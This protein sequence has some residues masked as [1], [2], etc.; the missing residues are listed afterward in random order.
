FWRVGVQ[1]QVVQAPQERLNGDLSL[2]P[3][4]RGAEAEVQPMSEGNM[5]VVHSRDVESVRI[6]KLI[7]I[8]VCRSECDTD[9]L[10]LAHG[11]SAEIKIYLC[12]P[13][14]NLNGTFETEELFDRRP[15]Q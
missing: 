11:F 10:A 8:T 4:Q 7:W 9:F 12:H 13:R 5:T 14:R 3:R 1:A 2:K 15:D 6:R